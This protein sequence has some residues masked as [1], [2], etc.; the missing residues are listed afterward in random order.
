MKSFFQILIRR[1][2]YLPTKNKSG[3]AIIMAVSA[4]TLMTYLAMEIM[5]ETSIEYI[6]N[7]QNLHRLKA[8]YAARAGLEMGLVRVKIF[9][10]LQPV[11][12]NLGG[13]TP[14]GDVA[15]LVWKLP[16][17]W[18]I[19]IPG[20]LNSVDA[21]LINNSGKE[22]L[23]HAKYKVQIELEGIKIDV[24]D[25]WSPSK[26]LRAI[27][28]RQLLTIFENKLRDDKDFFQKHSGVKFD[29]LINNIA[30]FMSDK[31]DSLNGG[32]K[33]DDYQEFQSQDFPPNR[34]F[35][36]LEEIRFVKGMTDEFFELL[37]PAITVY[38]M[39]AINPN[40]APPEVLKSL[41]PS[42]TDQIVQKVVQRRSDPKLG[43][44]FKATTNPDDR[45][46]FWAFLEGEGARLL[47]ETKKIPLV[48]DDY[49]NFRITSIGEANKV[50]STLVAITVDL[51]KQVKQVAK[52]MKDEKAAEQNQQNSDPN[53][54]GGTN[55][56]DSG[57]TTSTQGQQN[58][59]NSDA[60]TKG[61][62]R[63]VYWEEL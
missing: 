27:T 60:P 29:E 9:Q 20:F 17:N 35:I 61:P 25:L 19:E 28:K 62:P 40:K 23:M 48:F 5:Y 31:R 54:T 16:F 12:K 52:Y 2:R 10:Q 21:D 58:S 4:L 51:K 43:G 49:Y 37:K 34:A 3:V 55:P 8:H 33:K 47:D 44:P 6:V 39:R 26:G 22:S 63:I 38:G 45:D 46:S 32:S 41:D 53:N 57:N 50:Y 13:T 24:N 59:N 14:F 36:S 42:M 15:D 30:D 18:P 7:A 56:Q 1:S 11:L